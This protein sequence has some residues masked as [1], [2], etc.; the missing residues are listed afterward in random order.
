MIA[1]VPVATATLLFW[2]AL[3]VV[4]VLL[5]GAYSGMEIGCYRLSEVRLRL[6]AERHGGWWRRLLELNRHRDRLICIILIGN[7]FADYIATGS[8]TVLLTR[9]G[10]SER[11][12][13][14]YAT[15]AL[16]PALFVVGEMIP[17]ALMQIRADTLTVR[18]TWLLEGSRYLFTYTGLLGAVQA[19]TRGVLWLFGHRGEGA[20]VLSPHERIRAILLDQT[21]SG[22]LSPVQLDVA[23]SVLDVREVRTREAMTPMSRVVMIDE[24]ADREQL[25]EAAAGNDFTRLLVHASGDRRRIIG[26]VNVIEVLLPEE[27]AGELRPF[28]RPIVH[29]DADRPV[30]AS[31]VALREARCPMG[32]V[33]DV[34]GRPIGLATVKDLAEK[35]VG[36]VT[37]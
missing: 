34:R 15:I 10:L 33:H 21:A 30:S 6:E 13:E 23:R 3:C 18:G 29:L 4:G 35:I 26:F 19:A 14:L 27:P 1:V 16:A 36:D 8:A 25:E 31:L 9:M 12:T 7:S 28:I 22:L 32:L 24:D 37:P 2:L 5:S 11:E 17:K 20:E